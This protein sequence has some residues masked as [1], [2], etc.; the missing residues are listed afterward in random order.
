MPVG[1]N[2][3]GQRLDRSQEEHGGAIQLTRRNVYG[4]LYRPELISADFT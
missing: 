3:G 1:G 4:S 2:H